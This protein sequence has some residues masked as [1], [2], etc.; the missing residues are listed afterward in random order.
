MKM[1]EVKKEIIEYFRLAGYKQDRFEIVSRKG[2]RKY[3]KGLGI[4]Q[5]DKLFFIRLISG[6]DYLD[7]TN[8]EKKPVSIEIPYSY[9]DQHRMMELVMDNIIFKHVFEREYNTFIS[10]MEAIKKRR[11]E[12]DKQ[13]AEFGIG[14]N[15]K[16]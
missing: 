1:I 9:A 8:G 16:W 3:G 13:L 2:N 4:K 6:K 5:Q 10:L 14:V 11:V 12:K 7:P 15:K